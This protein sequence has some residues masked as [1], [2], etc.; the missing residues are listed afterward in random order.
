M[1]TIKFYSIIGLAILGLAACEGRS[2]EGYDN[3]GLSEAE[4]AHTRAL[5]DSSLKIMKHD[6]YLA[7]SLAD[8]EMK[9][10][11]KALKDEIDSLK[12]KK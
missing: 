3:A 9:K 12:K 2:D 10:E 11:I 5:I 8:S 7:D 6:L 4:L 1:K